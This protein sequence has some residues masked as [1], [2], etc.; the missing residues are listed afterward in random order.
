MTA[1]HPARPARTARDLEELGRSL[2]W[3]L[4]AMLGLAV[5]GFV[6]H[7][8]GSY[9]ELINWEVEPGVF[10]LVL[11]AVNGVV[12]G[13]LLWLAAGG[14]WAVARR[15][16]LFGALAVG[17]THGLH[18]ASSFLT[19]Y[20]IV[21]AASGALVAVAWWLASREGPPLQA[22]VAGVAWGIGLLAASAGSTALGLPWE[23]TPVG[24]ST[25]H[26]VQGLIVGLVWGGATVLIRPA[27]GDATSR[28]RPRAAGRPD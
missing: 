19:P 2:G 20:P 21:A 16:I 15:L 25:D 24:W 14:G 7:F 28:P 1:S 11:G 23:Q 13:I 18:D 8:P 4:A 10:G 5:G 6:L 27:A 12:F 3:I 17:S 22:A 26:A 9:G